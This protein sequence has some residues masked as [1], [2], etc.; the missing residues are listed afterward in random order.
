MRKQLVSRVLTTAALAAS[1]SLTA[2]AASAAPQGGTAPVAPVALGDNGPFAASALASLLTL[3]VAALSPALLPQTNID[4]APSEAG[5]DSD[6]DF[7]AGKTGAQ[8]TFAVGGVTYGSNLLGAPLDVQSN[9]ASA[10]APE[11]NE[12]TLLPLDVLPL[13]DLPVISSR[14]EANYASDVECVAAGSPLSQAD[15]TAADVT[16]LSPD[17]GQSVLALNTVSVHGHGPG[18]SSSSISTRSPSGST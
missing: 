6:V 11:V 10:P 3:D 8:R 12:A 15:Q 9:E 14:A 4:L 2:P 13:L 17:D 7:D 5:A 18:H 1:I 16:L